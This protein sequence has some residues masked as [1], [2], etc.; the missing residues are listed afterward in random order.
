M[1]GVFNIDKPSGISSHDVVNRLRRLTQIRR[2]GHAGTL[3]PL[4]T[5]VML[6]CVGRATRLIEYLV[7]HSKRYTATIRLGQTTDSY[8]SEGQVL[9]E[10]PFSH[11]TRNDIEQAIPQL[12]GP[13]EQLP[14]MY[15]A[16]KKDGQ[17][18]YKLARQGVEVERKP[19]S[20][21]IHELKFIS[22]DA[23]YLI[24]ETHVSSGTYIRSLAYDLGEAI[25]CGGHITQLRRTNVGTFDIEN[26]VALDALTSDNIQEAQLPMETAV[27]HL[28][29]LDISSEQATTLLNGRLISKEQKLP[30]GTIATLFC[31]NQ[32]WGLA[33]A[34]ENQWKAHKMVPPL[35]PDAE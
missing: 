35:N 2:I 23:P 16:I 25:G 28:P 12:S 30:V 10:R 29:R 4:A 19:R 8:D 18:L 3:D 26:S 9:L 22:Y 17:P 20:V 32:F 31:E 13:I 33:I 15:S 27:Q 6:L 34:K 11:I 14:P 7:G 5:G 1:E 24:I 21:T